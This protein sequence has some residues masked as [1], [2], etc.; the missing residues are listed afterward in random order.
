MNQALQIAYITAAATIFSALIMA[1]G[2]IIFSKL[3]GK[4]LGIFAVSFAALFVVLTAVLIKP[5]R[6]EAAGAVPS[7][8][9]GMWSDW[10]TIRVDS[11]D[12]REVETRKSYVYRMHVYVTQEN[13]TNYPRSLETIV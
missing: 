10:S 9:Y 8:N 5:A 2:P 13:A 4:K 12:T 3:K 7:T 6:I 1:F 11:S